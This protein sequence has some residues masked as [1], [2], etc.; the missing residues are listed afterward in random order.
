MTVPKPVTVRLGPAI[1][2]TLTAILD[3]LEQRAALEAAAA[4]AE[5]TL[6]PEEPTGLGAVV[7]NSLG[8]MFV[9]TSAG[10]FCLG[11]WYGWREITAPE[12]LSH[13]YEIDGG[14]R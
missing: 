5:T 6:P 10:W 9:R 1:L 14:N 2:E 13:G 12:I 3:K 7:R 4:A 8:R 11:E